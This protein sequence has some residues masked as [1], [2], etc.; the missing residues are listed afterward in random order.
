M[1]IELTEERVIPK[2]M[3]PNNGLLVEHLARYK[4]ASQYAKGRVLDLACG[5]G[6]GAEVLLAIG[7]GNCRTY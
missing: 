5:V 6:Y 7:E 1:T 2:K 4:F 3:H